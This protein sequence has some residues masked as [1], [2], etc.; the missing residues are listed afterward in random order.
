MVGVLLGK[1]SWTAITAP[2][3]YGEVLEEG[4]GSATRSILRVPPLPIDTVQSTS[5]T[6]DTAEAVYQIE[7]PG[8]TT[9]PFL[10]HTHLGGVRFFAKSGEGAVDITWEIEVRPFPIVA[11]LV[12][13]L[14]EMTA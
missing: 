6:D 12:E 14:L 2:I 11:P 5:S 10:L 1:R 13:K 8:W 7:N 4:G 3:P 9:L